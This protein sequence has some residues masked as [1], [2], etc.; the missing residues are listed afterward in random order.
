MVIVIRQ[1]ETICIIGW[2]WAGCSATWSFLYSAVSVPGEV[3]WAGASKRQHDIANQFHMNGWKFSL[4]IQKRDQMYF[5][6]NKTLFAFCASLKTQL[7]L[8]KSPWL[9]T[10]TIQRSQESNL[11]HSGSC[12]VFLWQSSQ[13]TNVRM[14]KRRSYK[15]NSYILF[16]RSL[17]ICWVIYL[18]FLSLSVKNLTP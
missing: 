10:R 3:G 9:H 17:F 6:H 5:V 12:R 8:K 16:L 11:N 18:F 2:M 1:T 7:H 14:E 4:Y 15:P 13:Y